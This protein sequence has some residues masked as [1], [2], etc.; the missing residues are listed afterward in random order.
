MKH[1]KNIFSLIIKQIPDFVLFVLDADGNFL[2]FSETLKKMVKKTWGTDIE[3]GSNVFDAITFEEDKIKIEQD[4]KRALSKE[5]FEE[6]AQYGAV[7]LAR[8]YYTSKWSPLIKNDEVVGAICTVSL[9]RKTSLKIE[10]A[11]NSDDMFQMFFDLSS[12][13][14][15]CTQ[16][17]TPIPCDEWQQNKKTIIDMIENERIIYVNQAM[18]Q[19]LQASESNVINAS[20]KEVFDSTEEKMIETYS[21]LLKHKRLTLKTYE[22]KRNGEWMWIEGNYVTICNEKNQIVGHF[23]SRRDITKRVEMEQLA[24][25][26]EYLLNYIIENDRTAVAVHDKDMRYIYVSQKY[27]DDFGISDVSLIGKKH[28]ELFLETSDKWRNIHKRALAGEIAKEEEDYYV[29]ANGQENWIR[30]E[31]RPWFDTHNEIGGIIVYVEIIN[32]EKRIMSVLKENELRLK[33]LFSQ[34]AIGISYGTLENE[35]DQVN[36][37]LC[38]I[39]GYSPQELNQ[40]TYQEISHP[41]DLQK[42]Y[43]NK[44]KLINKEINDFI[45]ESRL[46]KKNK[47]IVWANVT[48]TLIESE[49]FIGS[50][51]LMMFEDI[52]SRKQSEEKMIFLNYHDQLTGLYNRRFYEEELNRLDT[53][54]NL[55]MSL[56]V[57]DANGLKLINDAF[58]HVSGDKMIQII[59]DVFVKECRSDDIIARIGGDE[60]VVLLSKTSHEEA[61]LIANRIEKS[62]QGKHVNQ[63]PITVALGIATKEHQAT[64]IMDVFNEA[65]AMMYRK[66]LDRRSEMMNETIQIILESFFNQYKHEKDH[67]HRVSEMCYKMGVLLNFESQSLEKLRLAGLMHDIGKVNISSSILNKVTTLDKHD[68][69][70]I[71]RHSEIGYRILSAVSEFAEVSEYVLASH[72]RWDGKGY[73]K[74]LDKEKIPLASRI[75]AVADAY[76]SMVNVNSM[77]K[78]DKQKDALEELKKMA[79][80][81]FDPEVVALFIDHKIYAL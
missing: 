31:C 34:A 47:E 29:Q 33:A 39:T 61:K 58:G 59:A 66:K 42:Y 64:N 28:Y 23:A 78:K 4:F 75:I 37:K 27:K 69:D 13:G 21:Q 72:E 76:D 22:K 7:D 70:E 45:L 48:F 10:D 63:A 50:Y 40:L 25:Q 11:F 52:T 71:M 19:Q 6:S 18:L 74:G 17:N 46:I 2:I 41:L 43:Q 77:A 54:R 53:L 32:E 14:L 38:S 26:K 20:I 8:K 49:E 30:W 65:E 15:M 81:Q 80:L 16:L 35:F 79:D 60:F 36:Q 44:Q 51:I 9:M 67:A 62:L 24:Q 68:W 1:I 73:P 12:D 3:V 57:A 55:P 56:I 5:I